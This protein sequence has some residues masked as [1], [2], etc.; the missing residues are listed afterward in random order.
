MDYFYFQ[1]QTELNS[2]RELFSLAG[3]FGILF[4]GIGA[5]LF[6]AFSDK[7]GAGRTIFILGLLQI[8]S[9]I[10]VGNIN[11]EFDL[12]GSRILMGIGSIWCFGIALSVTGRS[13]ILK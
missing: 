10:W 12:F 1:L 11:S 13:I 5:P 2:G 6:G 7:Y 9:W 8:I 3:A 4:S